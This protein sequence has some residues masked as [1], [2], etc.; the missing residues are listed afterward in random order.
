MLKGY[1]DANITDLESLTKWNSRIENKVFCVLNE[2]KNHGENKFANF[3]TLK[4][5]ITE[6]TLEIN[7]KHIRQRVA[8]NVINLIFV[9]N[10]DYPIK[11]E[12]GDRRYL[13]L[14]VNGGH[15]GDTNY[16]EELKKEQ[17]EDNVYGQLLKFF[18]TYDIKD[19]N[20]YILPK[21][22]AKMDM[23]N[24]GRSLVDKFIIARLEAFK[25]GVHKSDIE[26][27]KPTE[28][29]DFNSFHL[30]LK[31]KCEFKQFRRNG[32]KANGYILKPEYLKIYE[33]MTETFKDD[34][35]DNDDEELEKADPNAF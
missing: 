13:V 17:N 21:T 11:I 3:D 35:N 1:S 31:A 33:E 19:F 6:P 27:L 8:Q 10:N 20:S 32:C 2:A 18:L 24:A 23:I 9:T 14:D 16:F 22:E 15:K 30:A 34:G 29:K 5:I 26:H 12:T 25:A 7:E 28:Y 4:A